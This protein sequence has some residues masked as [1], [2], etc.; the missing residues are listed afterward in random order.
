MDGNGRWARGRFLPRAFGHKAG[1]DSARAIM[2]HA[3]ERGVR[4]LTLYAFS[5]EN[6]LRPAFEVAQLLGLLQEYLRREIEFMCRHG[7]RAVFLGD[8]SGLSSEIA[9]A[10]EHMVRATAHN[11]RMTLALAVNYGGRYELARAATAACNAGLNAGTAPDE[12]LQL[13]QANLDTAQLPD[14]DLMIRTGGEKRL[15]NFLLW[16]S[17][18]AELYFCDTLWPDFTPVHFD[19]ALT[20]YAARQRRFGKTA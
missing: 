20:D 12:A 16:Q 11:T 7:L 3:A 17:A 6:R 9:A 8:L 1:A 10:A 18:Y 2:L 15:S 13:L 14:P 5:S 4:Y 19:T